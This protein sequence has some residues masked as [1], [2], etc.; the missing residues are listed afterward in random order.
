VS[1]FTQFGINIENVE[2]NNYNV[3][4]GILDTFTVVSENIVDYTNGIYGINLSD[5]PT[6][7][8]IENN[9]FFKISDPSGLSAVRDCSTSTV[10]SN[11]AINNKT[12]P[13]LNVSASGTLVVPEWVQT[14]NVIP[15]AESLSISQILTS[16][17]A[18]V[19]SSGI[20][21]VEVTNGGSLYTSTTGY[22][23]TGGAGSNSSYVV[24][25]WDGK[26]SGIRVGDSGSGYGSLGSTVPLTITNSVSG[27]GATAVGYVGLPWSQYRQIKIN[28]FGSYPISIEGATLPINSTM[29][30]V[31][32]GTS[33][34]ASAVMVGTA[35]A[36]T[37]APQWQQVIAGNSAS[38]SNVKSS[39]ALNT[40]YTN[41]T[42]RPVMVM[43][44][45]STTLSGNACSAIINGVLYPLGS[46]AI[47]G[48]L[49]SFVSFVV[50][51]GQTYEITLN[52]GTT[53]NCWIEL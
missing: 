47:T 31:F 9:K 12:I 20:A 7:V 43:C 22:T 39:R 4:F 34:S 13:T 19:G 49:W 48:G 52:G 24:F 11:N 2:G 8:I 42:G 1:N 44:Q 26:I 10:Y 41:T 14:F 46:A 30:I 18:N 50:P 25:P 51:A 16:T 3:G 21:Y 27:S 29:E 6:S 35:T 5:N 53:I 37:N 33:W 45:A 28:N 32:S 15:T 38:W 23:I 36:S 17:Q 40:Q